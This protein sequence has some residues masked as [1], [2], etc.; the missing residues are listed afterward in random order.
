MKNYRLKK[1]AVRF[2]KENHATSIKSFDFWD[3]IGVDLLALEEVEAVYLKYGQ[4]TSESASTLSGWD[5]EGGSHFLFTIHFP[6]TKHCEHDKF[7]N[8]KSIREL[9]NSVQRVINAFQED[10]YNGESNE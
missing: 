9:M 2:F 8:G 5:D 1:E 3:K 4:K 10:F 7:N 6:S